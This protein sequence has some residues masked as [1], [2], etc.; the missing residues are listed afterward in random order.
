MSA[1]PK[2][3]FAHYRAST[4]ADFPV[5]SEIP[6]DLFQG[7]AARSR[8]RSSATLRAVPTAA[9]RSRVRRLPAPQPTPLWLRALLVAQQGSAIA[10]WTLVGSVLVLYGWTVYAQQAWSQV[11]RKLDHLQ[12]N[13]QQIVAANEML[14]DYMAEQAEGSG[15]GLVPAKPPSNIFL[16]RAPQRPAPKPGVSVEANPQTTAD[17]PKPLGY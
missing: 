9:P 3:D 5:P 4:S 2:L 1:V 13:E 11:Y 14:K 12:Q 16:E 15:S 8:Q 7:Q 10:A 17:L 6:T